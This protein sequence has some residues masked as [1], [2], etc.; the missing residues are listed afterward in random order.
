MFRP[1]NF[2]IA[3]RIQSIIETFTDCKIILQRIFWDKSILSAIPTS[4]PDFVGVNRYSSPNKIH[5]TDFNRYS[6]IYK[7]L[8]GLGHARSVTLH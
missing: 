1:N 6:E 3:K 2:L 7:I 8:Q 5:F 4:F